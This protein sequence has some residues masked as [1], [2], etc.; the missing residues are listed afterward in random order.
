M[1]ENLV[2]TRETSGIVADHPPSKNPRNLTQGQQLSR[3]PDCI[4]TLTKE[5]KPSYPQGLDTWPITFDP[6]SP[7]VPLMP[8]DI[9]KH[10]GNQRP[11]SG[12]RHPASPLRDSNLCRKARPLRDATF[13][14]TPCGPAQHLS[15]RI[16]DL[17]AVLFP[18]LSRSLVVS[19]PPDRISGLRKEHLAHDKKCHFSVAKS[20]WTLL[21]ASNFDQSRVDRA[22]AWTFVSLGTHTTSA[23]RFRCFKK[24]ANS[25]TMAET[26]NFVVCSLVRI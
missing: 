25:I 4:S 14:E 23:W 10:A 21:S 16:F 7:F 15:P 12:P 6:M 20:T 19:R 17:Q 2:E 26:G 8:R 13:V 3:V 24:N 1:K 9:S 5:R 18:L 22:S 11:P